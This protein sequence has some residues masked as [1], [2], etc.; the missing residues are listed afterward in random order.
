MKTLV[1]EVQ[2]EKKKKEKKKE[3]KTQGWGKTERVSGF[4]KKKDRCNFFN[5]GYFFW[6][7]FTIDLLIIW[8]VFAFISYNH[9]KLELFLPILQ[10]LPY[11]S[12]YTVSGPAAACNGV[13]LFFPLHWFLCTMY[14]WISTLCTGYRWISELDSCCLQRV[15]CCFLNAIASI[16]LIE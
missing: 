2:I 15:D 14:C 10:A 6:S 11:F 1:F 13:L 5:I 7:K 12:W 16:A 4:S 3:K 8:T 9:L